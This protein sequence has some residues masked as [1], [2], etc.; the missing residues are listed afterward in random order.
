MRKHSKWLWAF[1]IVIMSVSLTWWGAGNSRNGGG[2]GGDNFGSLYGKKITRQDFINARNEFYLFYW[3]RNH[4]WPSNLKS[5]DMDQ[6]IYLRLLLTRKAQSLGIHVSDEAAGTAG[7][8]VLHSL[9]QGGQ[10]TSPDL[11]ESQ[12]LKPQGFTMEDFERFARNDLVIQ[13]LI[14]AIGLTGELV[15]S[16][17]ATELYQRDH[18]EL[19]AQVVFFS[20]SN[21][22]SQVP[23]TPAAVGQF[24][25]NYMAAYRLPDRVQVSYVAFDLS[26]FLATAEQKIG[27]TNLNEQVEANFRRYGMEAAPSAK[28][29]QEAR[30]YIRESLLRRLAL[31]EAAQKANDFAKDVFGQTPVRAE[32]LA[33]TAKRDGLTVQTT[34]P[35]DIQYGPAEFP[36]SASLIKAAFALTPDEPFAGPIAG[37]DGVYVIALDKSFPSEIPPFDQIRDRVTS[38]YQVM[39]GSMI[40]QRNGTN[41]VHELA[42][43]MAAGKTFAAACVS[44]GL[45]P[46]TLPPFSMGT[47][48]LS[49]LRDRAPLNHV[50]SV[51][52]GTPVGRASGFEETET[53]GFILFLEKKTPV[54]RPTLDVQLPQFVAQMRRE[55]ANEIFNAW[56]NSEAN[57]ELKDTPVFQKQKA[58]AQAKS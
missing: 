11:F 31:N 33:A 4:E 45:H 32:N 58:A 48:E 20:A 57:R 15:T 40:A 54:D 55:R 37:Q 35:F 49:Q 6:Q 51:A 18:Q 21:Y 52:L 50:K 13:Q 19:F 14:E 24:Y 34:K 2:S 46:E 36:A 28:T 5:D 38:D 44:A 42:A 10:R 7:A 56:L 8:A 22:F 9:D 39:Q 17:E 25:T 41:F 16:E 1:L 29:P 3:F 53:G 30:A 23:I 12:V 43:Q 27:K 47:A 26:N